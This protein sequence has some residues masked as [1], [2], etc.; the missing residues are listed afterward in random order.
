MMRRDLRTEEGDECKQPRVTSPLTFKKMEFGVTVYFISRALLYL[1]CER[2]R[3]NLPTKK[4]ILPKFSY[5]FSFLQK[6]S[7]YLSF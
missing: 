4:T 7:S 6:F 5:S 2:K 3:G 1:L